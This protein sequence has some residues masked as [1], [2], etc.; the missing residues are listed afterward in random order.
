VFHVQAVS[1]TGDPAEPITIPTPGR[2]DQAQRLDRLAPLI[3]QLLTWDLV[4]RSESGEFQLREDVQQRLQELSAVPA[5][6]TAQVY[7]GRK[8]EVCGLVRAT[9]MV[10]GARTCGPCSKPALGTAAPS[11]TEVGPDRPGHHGLRARWHRKAS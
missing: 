3:H 2:I 5:P 10:E 8:C 4:A 7:L 1:T 9:R 11:G 6:V